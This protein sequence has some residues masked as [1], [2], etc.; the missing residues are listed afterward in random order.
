[1]AK[2]IDY[3]VKLYRAHREGAFVVT[4]YEFGETQPTKQITAAGM[5]DLV[6][7]ITDFAAEYGEGCSASV[8][9][10]AP[11]KPPGFKKATETLYFNLAEKPLGTASAA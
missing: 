11:R 4:K 3:T 8:R 9:C 1:M 5:D 6:D 10:H 2:L 7:Q